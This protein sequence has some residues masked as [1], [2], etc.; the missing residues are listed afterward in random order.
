MTIKWIE[1]GWWGKKKS[2]QRVGNESL[3]TK[4]CKS[5]GAHSYKIWL[6]PSDVRQTM[7]SNS[8]SRLKVVF[9]WFLHTGFTLG[10]PFYK[11]SHFCD[12]PQRLAFTELRIKLEILKGTQT[13]CLNELFG[14]ITTMGKHLVTKESPDLGAQIPAWQSMLSLP[15]H[16]LRLRCHTQKSQH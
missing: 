12:R 1:A 14:V 9:P 7:A 11:G 16:Q 2:V 4:R 3:Q 13:P 10:P 5:L 8:E 15:S 6:T